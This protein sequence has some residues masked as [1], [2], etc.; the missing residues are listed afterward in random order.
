M[1]QLDVRERDERSRKKRDEEELKGEQRVAWLVPL[2]LGGGLGGKGRERGV[3]VYIPIF[4][5]KG[6][7]VSQ[8]QLQGSS[9]RR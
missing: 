5:M 9:E 3:L 8:E 6:P 7:C 1:L 2:S 4:T